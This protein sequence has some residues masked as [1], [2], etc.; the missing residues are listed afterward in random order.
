MSVSAWFLFLL[1]WGLPFTALYSCRF[2]SALA[3]DR[4][5]ASPGDGVGRVRHRSRIRIRLVSGATASDHRQSAGANVFGRSL[6][7]HSGCKAKGHFAK[8]ASLGNLVLVRRNNMSLARS[9]PKQFAIALLS[10]F[11]F[12][13]IRQGESSAIA[14]T[15]EVF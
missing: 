5:T 1:T 4:V 2:T 15:K 6:F 14:N 13:Q 10:L 9:A 7:H 3:M 8:I 11:F 12:I